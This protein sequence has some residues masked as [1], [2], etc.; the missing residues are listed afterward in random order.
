M[1]RPGVYERPRSLPCLNLGA[2]SPRSQLPLYWR[3]VAVLCPD[4]TYKATDIAIVHLSKLL[5]QCN[6]WLL[7]LDVQGPMTYWAVVAATTSEMQKIKL[8]DTLAKEL[9]FALLR[10][11]QR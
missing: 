10:A 6:K 5:V 8:S 4:K 3:A 2:E 9:V 7:V 11:R 1:A